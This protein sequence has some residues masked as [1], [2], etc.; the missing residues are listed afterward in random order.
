MIAT[1]GTTVTAAFD[2]IDAIADRR[3]EHGIW[4]HVDA[5]YGG[6]ALSP[7]ERR[8][9]SGIERA[10]SVVWNLHK[11]ADSPNSAPPCSCAS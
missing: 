2:P 4:L 8:R 11:M 9:L 1:A 6:A 7:I 5:A 10:D 3:E